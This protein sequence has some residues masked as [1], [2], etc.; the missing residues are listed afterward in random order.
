MLEARFLL[1][2]LKGIGET[3]YMTLVSTAAAY[4]LGI[5]MGVVLY[6]TAKGSIRPNAALNGALGVVV[7]T[8]RSV[9]FLIL[10]VAVIPV[11]RFIVGTSLGSTATIVPLVIGAAPFVGRMVEASLREVDSGV[12]EAGRSMG[13]SLSQLI[14]RVLLPEAAPSLISGAAIATTTILG[15]SAM[16][17][18]VGGGGLGTIAINYGY[19]QYDTGVMLVTVVLLV[20]IVQLLQSIGNGVARRIDK[21]GK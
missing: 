8:L 2:L 4:A 3:L 20:L 10:L 13:A 16:A 11:T 19:Y 17:G 6:I 5:P 21:R 14:F 18:F 9:P 1:L 12:I 7:N 15:Y